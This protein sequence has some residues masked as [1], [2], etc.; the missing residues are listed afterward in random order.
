[1]LA[2][3][4]HKMKKLTDSKGFYRRALELREV[5]QGLDHPATLYE[6]N[7]LACVLFHLKEYM[8]SEQL[9][10]R[11]LTSRE[12]KLGANHEDTLITVHD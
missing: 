4:L 10:Q 12:S 9:Y 6:V 5:L 7:D 1:M 3:L 11:A 8:E 2:D